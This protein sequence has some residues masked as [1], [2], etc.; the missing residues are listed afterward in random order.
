MRV[1]DAELHDYAW[2]RHDGLVPWVGRSDG[3]QAEA[4]FGDIDSPNGGVHPLLVKVLAAAAPLSIQVHPDAEAMQA[5]SRERTNSRL[6]HDSVEK[7]E[8]I[9]ALEPFT[10]FAGFRDPATAAD[11]LNRLHLPE[12]AAPVMDGRPSDA[13]RVLLHAAD[14]AARQAFERL[15]DVIHLVLEPNERSAIET[16]RAWYPGDRGVLVAL[17]LQVHELAPGDALYVPAGVIHSYV[18]GLGVEV[19]TASDNVLRLGL[20]QKA[21]AVDA[22]LASLRAAEPIRL[23]A[24]G[25]R[26]LE[27]PGAPFSIALLEKDHAAEA[28]QRSARTVLPLSGSVQCATQFSGHATAHC[29]QALLL[30]ERDG[31]AT[32]IADGRTVVA[33]FTH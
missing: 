25:S 6:L 8:L 28:F 20:T 31:T 30:E 5:L 17:L 33:A 14:S 15:S 21:I 29:G 18:N 23:R 3:P 26:Q 27:V 9:L 4:W 11:L 1:V 32:V 24:W 12:A 19:M 16:V 10:T 2:G 7:N 22:A 13:I